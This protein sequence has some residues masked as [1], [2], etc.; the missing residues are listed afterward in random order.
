MKL[1]I[2]I[3]F[4]ALVL[5]INTINRSCFALP[6]IPFL[7][8]ISIK[9]LETQKKL[10]NVYF[11]IIEEETGKKV[12]PSEL[13]NDS[14]IIVNLEPEQ[15]YTATIFK[16]GYVREILTISTINLSKTKQLK[17][18]YNIEIFGELFER[19]KDEDYSIFDK[20]FGSI[21]FNRSIEDFVWDPNEVIQKKEEEIKDF[22]KKARRN[23]TNLV[24][25]PIKKTSNTSPKNVDSGKTADKPLPKNVMVQKEPETLDELLEV[26]SV[27]TKKDSINHGEVI[28]TKITFVNGK[29][30]EY[31]MITFDWGPV[32]FKKDDL[33]I[34]ENT[35]NLMKEKY[36]F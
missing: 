24:S 29:I 21:K 6:K 23:N 9:D 17:S 8:S 28:S 10:N 27:E 36:K 3:L 14:P 25:K 32:Y 33:D 12:F 5:I 22:R 13:L 26:S 11:E 31:K 4:F 15:V 1:F 2:K 19:F 34:P 35:Y 20:S 18:E 30:T 7:I 16:L